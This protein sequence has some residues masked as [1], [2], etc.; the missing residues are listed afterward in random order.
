MD[1]KKILI[2]DDE[3]DFCKSVKMNLELGSEF[4]VEI[5]LSGDEGIKL[6][7]TK[8][9]N[10]ILLDIIMPKMDGFEVL[11]SLK[12][13]KDTIA[14]PVVML[15]AKTDDA[16]KL[17]ASMLYDEKYLSKTIE[18]PQLKAEIE[19]VLRRSGSMQ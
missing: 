4:E 14:I 16:S 10:L 8:K 6:A 12:K 7:K 18:S 13:D 2:I 9:P 1:R 17:R 5:A 19:K 3:A 15:T 11:K